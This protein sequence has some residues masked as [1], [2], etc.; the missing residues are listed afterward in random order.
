[1]SRTRKLEAFY[2]PCPY[3]SV[4]FVGSAKAN[5]FPNVYICIKGRVLSSITSL[6]LL[7]ELFVAN[8]P[9][10]ILDFTLI[11]IVGCCSHA[12]LFG[13]QIF[14]RHDPSDS[15]GGDPPLPHPRPNSPRMLLLGL[16]VV[17]CWN[18]GE[19][20]HL[21]NTY[22]CSSWELPYIFVAAHVMDHFPLNLFEAPDK[23]FI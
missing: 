6:G 15:L 2:I 7:A 1:M 9:H 14:T 13:L 11:Y 21:L 8:V 17:V 22:L 20:F 10:W 3:L 12:S 23:L 18:S 5:P 16:S 4:R 19:R